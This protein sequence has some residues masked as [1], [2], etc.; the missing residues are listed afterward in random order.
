M[1]FLYCYFMKGDPERVQE[2][3]PKHAAYWR[4]L[5]LSGYVGG[6]FEDRSGGLISFDAPVRQPAEDLV[7]NDPFQRLDLVDAWW[8]KVWLPQ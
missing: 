1:R 3:A 6:P 5:D 7:A 8:L 4:S 2:A